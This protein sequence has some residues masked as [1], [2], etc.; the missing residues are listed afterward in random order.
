MIAMTDH[1][2]DLS[3]YLAESRK[4]P[5]L[6]VEQ[7]QDLARRWRDRCDPDAIQ[8]LVGSHL[9]LVIKIARSNRGYGLPMNDLISEGMV[10]LMQAAE[11]FDPDRGFRFATYALWWIRATIQEYVLHSWSLVKIGTTAAQKRMF[12]NLRRIKS[13]LQLLDEGDLAPEAVAEIAR[14]LG[15]REAEVV[16]MNRRL[17]SGDQSLNAMVGSDP[18][19]AWQDVLVDERLD[20]ETLIANADEFEK[21]RK[22]VHDALKLLPARERRIVEQRKMRD[23]PLT[24]EQLAQELGVSRERVR[25]L[26]VRALET[27]RRSV[28]QEAAPRIRARARRGDRRRSLSGALSA[29]A[30]RPLS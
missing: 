2:N 15:V 22:L 27:I 13:G 3:R 29:T 30:E 7:E 18:N 20:P 26:E 28:R 14:E 5:L 19:Q 8:Q 17:A 21:R 10:G 6:T 12:F 23:E 11:R 1:E 25:Q 16:E 9:R 24:L 4:Y